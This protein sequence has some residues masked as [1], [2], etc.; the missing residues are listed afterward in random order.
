M[1]KID[2]FN[3]IWPSRF[4][5]MLR[6]VTGQMT[7]ITRRSEAVPMMTGLDDRFRV[8]D[9]FDDYSQILSLV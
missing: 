2:I 1:K 7:D 9:K 8:M 3:H 5:S 4:Y 6:D